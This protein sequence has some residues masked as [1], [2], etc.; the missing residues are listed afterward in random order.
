MSVLI[1]K[2]T[3]LNLYR[4]M[5]K[6][7]K[8]EEAVNHLAEL[9][10]MAPHHVAIGEEAVYAG[11]CEPLNKK[12]MITGSHRGFH[13]IAR[14]IDL[15]K[16]FAELYGKVTGTNRGKG[17]IMHVVAPEAGVLAQSGI[18][19]GSVPLAVGAAFA[20]QYK[21]EPN[22]AVAFLGDGAANEGVVH[23]SMNIAAA[24][25]L[26]VVFVIENNGVAIT[27]LTEKATGTPDF[28]LR[29]QGYG[30]PGVQVDGQDV[31]AV[32]AAVAEAARYAHTGNG[33]YLVECKTMRFREHQEGPVFDWLKYVGY[34]NKGVVDYWIE[35]LDPIKIYEEKLLERG[36]RKDELET[37][38][39]E[40]DK[41]IEE[42]IAFA[43]ESPFPEPE[44]L[45]TNNFS[46]PL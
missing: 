35:N 23:E 18:V 38:Q 15:N 3:Q 4:R 9:G 13:C 1:T 10:E 34:R 20:A 6:V 45:Y 28:Y 32:Y 7:R 27:T 14:G 30:M 22:I 17:G 19:G 33:P 42:A 8:V 31:E 44:E 11:A 2:E 46:T 24:W 36:F 37:I 25:K 26:P 5:L 41:E 12:D 29:A 16:W 40:L 39:A 43:K 21:E